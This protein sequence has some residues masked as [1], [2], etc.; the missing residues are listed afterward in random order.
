MDGRLTFGL[1]SKVGPAV[2]LLALTG[3]F[4]GAAQRLQTD[5]TLAAMLSQRQAYKQEFITDKHSPL[6]A[7]DTGFLRF[8]PPSTHYVFV[9]DVKEKPGSGAFNMPTHSGKTKRYRE[10]GTATF[11]KGD[12][13][14][15]LHIYQSPD[16]IQQEAYKDHLFIPFNDRSNE[17]LTYGG[18][19]YL[20]IK[21]G[22]VRNGR[23]TLDFNRCYNP[24][25]AY[26][27]GY[28]CP[29]PPAENRLPVSIE[30]GE[31]L[32]GREH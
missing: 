13:V 25:C 21:T 14:L 28:S 2:F 16:L 32:F 31:M 17:E 6:T 27:D 1:M 4:S 11:R 26:K 8:F 23:L 9:A 19:R 7:A 22:D 12:T 3:A 30:A 20:D 18:G 24:Y 29:I 10:W 5:S 15:T